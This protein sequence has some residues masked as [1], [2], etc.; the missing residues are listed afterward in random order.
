MWIGR[1]GVSRGEM[2]RAGGLA[3]NLLPLHPKGSSKSCHLWGG[4]LAEQGAVSGGLDSSSSFP[5]SSVP[6]QSE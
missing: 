3:T 4:G 5:H 6:H 1:D 2:L